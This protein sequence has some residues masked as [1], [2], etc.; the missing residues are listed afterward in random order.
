MIDADKIER[1]LAALDG[2][3][4]DDKLHAARVVYEKMTR[5][6]AECAR[7]FTIPFEVVKKLRQL[8]P[9]IQA[10]LN[11]LESGARRRAARLGR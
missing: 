10:T 7:D 11:R 4:G 5:A 9:V 6:E 3:A 1:D 2:L 8:I